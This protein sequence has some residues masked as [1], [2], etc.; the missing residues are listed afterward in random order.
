MATLNTHWRGFWNYNNGDYSLS[1]VDSTSLDFGISYGYVNS[2]TTNDIYITFRDNTSVESFLMSL[3]R[4][5]IPYMIMWLYIA[6]SYIDVNAMTPNHLPTR[7]RRLFELK[8]QNPFEFHITPELVEEVK[9][10]GVI[11]TG[12][13][14]GSNSSY[15]MLFNPTYT[16]LSEYPPA[17]L[18]NLLQQG[19]FW[20][21]DI[22]ISWLSTYQAKFEM[23]LWQ[24]NVKIGETIT[25]TTEKHY[26][27][28]ANTFSDKE[29]A[30][31]KLRVSNQQG[32]WTDWETK[33]LSLKDVEATISNLIVTGEYWE[34][35]ITF[36]WQSTDQ[37]QFK[38]EVWKDNILQNTYTGTTANRYTLPKNTL[39]AGA[40]LIKVWVGYAN[41][42]V[43]NQS[44][45]ITLKDITPTLDNL[46]LSGSNIDYDLILTW[47][48]TYQSKAEIEIYKG[49]DKQDTITL[50][51]DNKYVIANNTL[52][53]GAY[54][55]KVRVAYTS[56]TGDRW[57]EFK[58][59]NVTLIESF[60]SIGALQ[61]DGIIVDKNDDIRCW[62]TSNN[63]TKYTLTCGDYT[64]SG[65]TEKEHIIPAG[66][67]KVGTYS[68][69]LK[70]IYVTAQGVQKT[71]SKTS[72]FIVT[73][74]PNTP[75]ITSSDLFA[76]N[77]P[78]ITWDSQEQ[79]G[80]K[81]DIENSQG[82]LVWTSDW[83]NGL[84]TR[85]KC[86]DYL[87]NGMY[88]AKVKIMNE[89]GL[90]SD[91][92]IKQFEINV[93]NGREIVLSAVDV[94]F[95]KKL[96]WTN[97]DDYYQAFYIIRNGE[98]IAKTTNLEYYDY[99]CKHGE[100]TYIVRGVTGNDTYKDSNLLTT[101]LQLPYGT[102]ATISIP[103]ECIDAE[104]QRNDHTNDMSH[105]L[106]STVI[107]LNGRE[108]P[109][110]VIGEHITEEYVINFVS[111]D[112]DKFIAMCDRKETFV[113]RNR[114]GKV[115][116]LSITNP[117]LKQDKFG[118][119]YSCT[120]LK[121]DYKEVIDYD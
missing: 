12:E 93:V 72:K 91:Y 108:N 113:Y 76:Y 90:E 53:T 3:P 109:V 7:G 60:P 71:E 54:T 8:N 10:K 112:C 88:K 118:A 117:R 46:S 73:G 25:G 35:D 105:D 24:K 36:S 94:E 28:P 38:I 1:S 48:S 69:T 99:T 103:K 47:D 102:L 21:R 62:W 100:S 59:I 17:T 34:D 16:V 14:N 115:L 4:P 32:V 37:Q 80:F 83:Q 82:I 107:Y 27:I 120:G 50:N 61:P 65:A 39:T 52:T 77:R 111:K 23:E 51:Q 26:V 81:C 79:L 31:I 114:Q 56:T 101:R 5:S 49:S 63:Q 68:L 18:S 97:D 78:I 106:N 66:T 30:L 96:Y 58:S 110:V 15:K 84:I 13:H 41:R 44:K 57:S 22:T 121:V 74:K 87:P 55:F 43:N 70:V 33:N 20:E 11:L 98:V 92:A 19:N 29:N 86:M 85:I 67:F 42:F 64:Y 45:N 119:L 6:N 40:Y 9:A 2:M 95:G 89:F 104:L 116:F 75:T